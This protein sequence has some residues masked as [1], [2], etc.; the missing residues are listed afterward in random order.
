M[1]CVVRVGLREEDE[2]E[3]M[4]LDWPGSPNAMLAFREARMVGRRLVD[5]RP[6]R[7]ERRECRN[8]S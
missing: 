7:G 2:W 6:L 8:F 1:I 4:V 5:W 3:A